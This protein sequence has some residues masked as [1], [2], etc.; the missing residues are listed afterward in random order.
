MR[1]AWPGKLAWH[2]A[3]VCGAQGAKLAH[4]HLSQV[5]FAGMMFVRSTACR[6]RARGSGNMACGAREQDDAARAE[7]DSVTRC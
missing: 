3:V 1:M 4:M 5:W 6:R 2:A 7:P